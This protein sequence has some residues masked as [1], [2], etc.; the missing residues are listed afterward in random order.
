MDG[1]EKIPQMWQAFENGA[2]I[3]KLGSEG[4]I[5]VRDEEHVQGARATLERDCGTAPWTVTCGIHGW[6]F[7]TRFLASEAAAE[8]PAILDELGAILD[9]IPRVDDLDAGAKTG[10]VCEAIS[11][12]VARFS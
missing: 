8:F 11:R 7:H 3:G 9:I 1:E 4:G 10:A 6:F 2:T 5:I 12:F